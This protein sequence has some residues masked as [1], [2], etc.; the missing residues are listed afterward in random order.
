MK[1]KE[2]ILN[3]KRVLK[4][5]KNVDTENVKKL[6]L[7]VRSAKASDKCLVSISCI[8][9][10]EHL[11]VSHRNKIPSWLCMQEMKEMFF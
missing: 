2:E 11:S 8:D 3:D 10:W 9:G 7:E 1:D 6:K 4:V 5:Y